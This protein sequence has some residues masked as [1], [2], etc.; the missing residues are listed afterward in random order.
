MSSRAS[1]VDYRRRVHELYARVRR[2]GTG[3]PVAFADFV[4]TRDALFARHPQ[5][6]LTEDRR[7]AFAGLSYHPYDPGLRFVVPLDVTVPRTT[8]EMRLADDGVVTR[9]RFARVEVPFPTGTASLSLFWIGGYGGGTFLPFRDAT[10]GATSYGGG[11]YLLDTI[12]GADLGYEG[13]DLGY[14]GA[15]AGI[16]AAGVVLDFN[17]AYHPSCAYDARWDCP[18][19]PPENRLEVA[20][21]AGE[22]LGPSVR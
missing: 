8:H 15:G 20:V 11:R 12:K 6:P 19:A 10:N 21:S 7:A 3:S 1:V 22:R 17:Y 4:A 2:A 16:P 13:A 5:S 14:E 9:E 18:L